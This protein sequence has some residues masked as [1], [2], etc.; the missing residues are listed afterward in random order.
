M[1][2][3]TESQFWQEE[4][5]GREVRQNKEHERIRSYIE[6]NPERAGLAQQ[7]CQYRWSSAVANNL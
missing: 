1:P 2:A 5:Y 4:N 7:A 3:Q 6:S